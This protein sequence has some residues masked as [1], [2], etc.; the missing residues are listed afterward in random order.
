MLFPLYL[1]RAT[2]TKDLVERF[3]MLICATV[4]NFYINIGFLKPLNPILG[5]TCAGMYLD[6]TRM[7]AE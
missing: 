6:G 7:Y 1:N 3:K 4:G 2:A 5:E